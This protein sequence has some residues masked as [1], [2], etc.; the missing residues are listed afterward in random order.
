[1]S[2]VFLRF[3]CFSPLLLPTIKGSDHLSLSLTVN[4]P[5]IIKQV[6]EVR[7]TKQ[8]HKHHI[9][10]AGTSKHLNLKDTADTLEAE[11]QRQY[12]Q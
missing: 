1:M 6:W 7:A 10:H 11:D 5:L 3:E 12:Q 9:E 2:V 8:K 4:N